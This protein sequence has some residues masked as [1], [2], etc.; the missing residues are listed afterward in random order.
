[1]TIDPR[2]W[3][4]KF[5]MTVTVGLGT[6][7]Q[8]QVIN[9]VQTMFGMQM[10]AIQAGLGDVAVTPDNIAAT[11]KLAAKALFPKHADQ[12]VSNPKDMPPKQPQPNPDLLKIQLAAQQ[13][14]DGLPA[15]ARQDDA[16][17]HHAQR[18]DRHGADDAGERNSADANKELPQKLAPA[19][20][21]S[22]SKDTPT[23]RTKGT[24]TTRHT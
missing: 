7:S 18:E 17:V 20:S 13:G 14:E 8:V 19:S 11:M 9:A 16:G 1:V 2:E 6:N 15:E 5:N 3:K 21:E 12:L 23:T 22:T 10:T 24:G 4:D